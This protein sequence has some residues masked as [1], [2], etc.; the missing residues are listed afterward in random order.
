QAEDGIRYRNVTGVQT[1]ALSLPLLKGVE[2]LQNVAYLKSLNPLQQRKLS[3]E[4]QHATRET[5]DEVRTEEGMEITVMNGQN[6]VRIRCAARDEW[7][8]GEQGG[9]G[10]ADKKEDCRESEG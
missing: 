6:T 9:G 1:C 5:Q 2:R 7:C 3:V 8:K 4:N 10:T